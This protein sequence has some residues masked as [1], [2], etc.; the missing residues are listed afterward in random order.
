MFLS[1][2]NYPFYDNNP[3]LVEFVKN[4]NAK[5][6]RIAIAIII[7]LNKEGLLR[8]LPIFA[9]V[10]LKDESAIF[11]NRNDFPSIRLCSHLDFM[12]QAEDVTEKTFEK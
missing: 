6:C 8:H 9:N 2:D 4:T 11:A 7:Y 5:N 10:N 12:G 3:E 1:I